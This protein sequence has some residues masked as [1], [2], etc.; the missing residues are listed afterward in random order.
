MHKMKR[1]GEKNESPKLNEY[2]L[3]QLVLSI[4]QIDNIVTQKKKL[5]QVTFILL[6]YIVRTNRTIKEKL[7]LGFVIGSG[8]GVKFETV[9]GYGK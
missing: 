7:D 1:D 2:K 4:Y 8:I 5:I 3:N 9:L 6:R